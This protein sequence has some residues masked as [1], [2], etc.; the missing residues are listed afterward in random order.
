VTATIDALRPQKLFKNL[1]IDVHAQV[2]PPLHVD[3]DQIRQVLIN[4]CLNAAQALA[5]AGSLTIELLTQDD[6]VLV[7]V[8]DNGPGI[9]SS[10]LDQVFLPFFSTKGRGEGT[11]LGLSICRR[12]I[13][14]HGGELTA[15]NLPAGGALFRIRLPIAKP[16]KNF[17]NQLSVSI[18]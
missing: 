17:D 18:G 5:G 13:E 16:E 8:M 9:P 2:L 14:E 6:F 15:A 7:D 3:A 10:A 4:L 1:K 11:G 12:L